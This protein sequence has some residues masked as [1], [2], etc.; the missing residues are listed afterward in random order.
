MNKSDVIDAIAKKA[1]TTKVAAGE[2]FDAFQT[3][4]MEAVSKGTDVTLT[5]FLTIK[6]KRRAARTGRNPQTGKAISIPE[7]NVVSVSIG[8]TFKN[9]VKSSKL[10]KAIKKKK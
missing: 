8:T 3:I 4:V 7:T 6:A 9:F 5:G 1:G 10:I 2:C